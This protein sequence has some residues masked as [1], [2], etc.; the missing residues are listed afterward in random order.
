MVVSPWGDIIVEAK[1]EETVLNCEIDI[2][3]VETYQQSIPVLK[4]DIDLI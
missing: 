3:D 1:D 2:S 4:N